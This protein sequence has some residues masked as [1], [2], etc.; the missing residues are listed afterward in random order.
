MRLQRTV[1]STAGSQWKST[2]GDWPMSAR[3]FQMR[4]SC[5]YT[6]PENA[7]ADLEV[8]VLA[9]GQWESF[10]L[11]CETAGFLVFVYAILS[12]Q[13]LYL[14]TNAAER[15]LLLESAQGAIELIASED[16]E[17]QKLR[18]GFDVKLQSGRA[19][20]DDVSYIVARMKQCP[21][22]RNLKAIPDSDTAV[23]FA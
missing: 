16:W 14:R 11:N 4:L 3:N 21:V 10:N 12:C 20:G 5:R 13:H 8:E 17:V 22:S 7:V 15:G 1:E 6:E 18:I 9:D 2:Q 19:S 23:C